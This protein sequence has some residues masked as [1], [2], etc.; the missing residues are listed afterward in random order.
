MQSACRSRTQALSKGKVQSCA[1]SWCAVADSPRHLMHQHASP[2]CRQD[3][4]S[5][6]C[7]LLRSTN[8]LLRLQHQGHR[9]VY[10]CVGDKH[11]QCTYPGY[12]QPG[13]R[14]GWTRHLGRGPADR[15]SISSSSGLQLARCPMH[16]ALALTR[17]NSTAFSA[18]SCQQHCSTGSP[19]YHT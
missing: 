13:C 16:G 11:V 18:A 7:S 14:P 4:G 2:Q 6:R 1:V 19:T 5:E 10:A 15:Y 17:P 12:P 8:L 3:H 9:C